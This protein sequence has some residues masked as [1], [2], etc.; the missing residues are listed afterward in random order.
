M[1]S[2]VLE[3]CN[4]MSLNLEF[5][6]WGSSQFIRLLE[7]IFKL[8]VDRRNYQFARSAYKT[9]NEFR[10]IHPLGATFMSSN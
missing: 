5:D 10:R 2:S 1:L 4:V 6:Y 8:V 3:L 7:K 9:L